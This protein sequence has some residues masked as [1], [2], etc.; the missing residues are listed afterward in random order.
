MKKI[1]IA[2]LVFLI[3]C[4]T[5]CKEKKNNGDAAVI[6]DNDQSI[7]TFGFVRCRNTKNITIP[8]NAGIKKVLVH[9]GEKVVEGQYLF[10]LDLSEYNKQTAAKQTEIDN[11][12]LQIATL[13]QNLDAIEKRTNIQANNLR[14][15]IASQNENLAIFKNCIETGSSP[16]Y[17]KLKISL[18]N[19]GKDLSNAN[20]DLTNNKYLYD[21]GAISKLEYQ[22]KVS[23][24]ET[25]DNQI[26]E[27]RLSI[28][29]LI[30]EY[31]SGIRI[32][33]L[34]INQKE[35]DLAV[36]TSDSSYEIGELQSSIRQKENLLSLAK[37]DMQQLKSSTDSTF[38]KMDISYAM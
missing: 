15:D 34:S 25:I 30:Q 17:K 18:E 38:I 35:N 7:T 6:S 36:L 1:I 29:A 10:Q 23:A 32:L 9:E 24:V 16:E 31:E 4:L 27:L 21:S 14:H 20:D 28:D 22:T 19:A 33:Q 8:F 5:A 26:I 2:M 37:T 13:K 3:F 11:L 12:S